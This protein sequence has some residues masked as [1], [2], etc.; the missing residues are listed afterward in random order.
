[1]QYIFIIIWLAC[2]GAATFILE[3]L[4]PTFMQSFGIAFFFVAAGSVSRDIFK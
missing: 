3:P 2:V 4:G 1:M